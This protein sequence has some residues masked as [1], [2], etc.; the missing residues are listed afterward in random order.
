MPVGDLA[1][2]ACVTKTLD[3]IVIQSSKDVDFDYVV[4]GVRKAFKDHEA[5][6][7][8]K[9]FVPRS[10]VD[11]Y[12]TVGLPAESIRRLKASGILH[13]DGSIDMNTVRRLGWDKLQTWSDRD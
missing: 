9:D 13:E 12:F 10:A 6:S 2:M 4:N 7:E 11:P 1:V 8:N 3:R 5:I